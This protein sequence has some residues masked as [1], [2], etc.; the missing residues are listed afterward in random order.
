MKSFLN[1]TQTIKYLVKYSFFEGGQVRQR[2]RSVNVSSV[3]S[4]DEYV[5]KKREEGEGK[6]RIS[7][8]G[9]G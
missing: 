8:K 1:F 2:E 7:S 9:V 5:K 3:R 4:M 6:R